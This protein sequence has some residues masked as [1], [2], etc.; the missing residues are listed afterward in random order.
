[1][2]SPS[3]RRNRFVEALKRG[4]LRAGVQ[5]DEPLLVAVSGGP[6]SVALLLGLVE[7]LEARRDLLLVAHFNHR[8]RG[9]A[10]EGDA[11]FVSDLCRDL[12]IRSVTGTGDVAEA[13]R[14]SKRSLEETARR[15]RYAFLSHVAH[16]HGIRC[17]ATGHT[18]DDQAE[19]VLLRATRGAGLDGLAAMRPCAP[20][21]YASAETQVWV[22]RPLLSVARA[23]TQ[24]F[25][26]ARGAKPRRDV[27]NEDVAIPRNRVRLNVL[28]ALAE[29]NPQVRTALARLAEGAAIELDWI[30]NETGVALRDASVSESATELLLD[31]DRL[32]AL[33]PAL[34][35]HVLRAGFAHL[36]GAGPEL[37]RVHVEGAVDLVHGGSGRTL[38]LPGDVRLNSSYKELAF[39]RGIRSPSVS[40]AGTRTGSISVPGSTMLRD[41]DVGE[42][43]ATFERGPQIR[44]ANSPFVAQLDADAVGE[45]LRVRAW[46]AGDRFQPLGMA[47]S[48]KLQ[49]FFVDAHVPSE[50][51]GRVALIESSRG[52]AWVVGLR[53]AEWAKVTASTQR[54]VRLEATPTTECAPNANSA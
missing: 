5:L 33:H 7:L 51:R 19:T 1:M 45:R 47:Q 43:V 11:R 44:F 23:E 52:I 25:C 35:R 31:R 30:R 36:A 28:P 29:I 18:L 3:R 54:A 27:T 4:L 48:K 41:F 32:R 53:I 6:D 50:K 14:T 12:G 15:L 40:L 13:R 9:L 37:G 46:R 38:D 10:S 49:D 39:S 16:E 2:T 34:L 17:V 8:L 24:R 26:D 20:L 21:P 42:L 22:V